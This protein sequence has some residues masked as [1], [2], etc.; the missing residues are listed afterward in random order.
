MSEKVYD[1]FSYIEGNL[2][3]DLTMDFDD[4]PWMSPTATRAPV[5]LVDIEDMEEMDDLDEEDVSLEEL[6]QQLGTKLKSLDQLRPPAGLATG[7]AV[8]DDFL[9]W[10]GIP[11][12]ELTLFH[13]KPG[14]GATSLW[15]ETAQRVHR[16]K[17]WAAWVNSDWELMP[18]SLE[19]HGL[20]L[21]R[22][23]VVKKPE[24]ASQLFWVLQELISSSLFE[25]IGCHLPEGSLKTHQLQKL[26]KLART[27][28]VAFVIISH[29]PRWITNQIFSLV[30]D[31]SRD[32]FTVKRALHRPTPFH[33]SG[34]LVY[35]SL[36]SQLTT[37]PRSLVG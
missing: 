18:S 23:L 19:Q 25:I 8:F 37:K 17:K 6:R 22:L 36:M 7:L 5:A 2:A 34:S 14:T 1:T 26:K 13:S 31:C 24:E 30:I 21:S 27:H 4:S 3:G 35:E 20:D 11:K 32:F 12:G 16:E 29:N 10:R 33:V 9:L 15:L 28:Q